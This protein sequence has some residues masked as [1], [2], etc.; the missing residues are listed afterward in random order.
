MLAD[1]RPSGLEY[2][3]LLWEKR[4]DN[5][6]ETHDLSNKSNRNELS[7]MKKYKGMVEQEIFFRTMNR[8][9]KRT[10]EDRVIEFDAESGLILDEH[11][12]PL[13]S[14]DF[15]STET[16]IIDRNMEGELISTTNSSDLYNSSML[17]KVELY[18]NWDYWEAT[19]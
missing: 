15:N 19:K 6:K 13:R 17:S 10:S 14:L 16:G 1:L 4:I 5:F 3:E 8:I 7:S 9:A 12:Y 11:G 2:L 18:T